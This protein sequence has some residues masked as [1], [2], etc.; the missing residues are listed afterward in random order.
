MND[1]VWEKASSEKRIKTNQSDVAKAKRAAKSNVKASATNSVEG[2]TKL[3]ME[4]TMSKAYD[5]AMKG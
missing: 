2:E 5:R 3:T 4:E 1:K